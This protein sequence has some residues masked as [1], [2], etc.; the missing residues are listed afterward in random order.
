M[1]EANQGHV[2]YNESRLGPYTVDPAIAPTGSLSP[3]TRG[4]SEQHDQR[5]RRISGPKR[6]GDIVHFERI[7]LE[8]KEY[9][10]LTSVLIWHA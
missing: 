9:N 2:G 8:K 1:A 7:D 5:P 3:L 10:R 6:D 4:K